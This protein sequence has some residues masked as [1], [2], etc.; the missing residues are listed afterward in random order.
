MKHPGLRLAATYP[1]RLLGHIALAV[2]I[3]LEGLFERLGDEVAFVLSESRKYHLRNLRNKRKA[4]KLK[5]T[6]TRDIERL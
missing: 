1:L 4:E 2:F 6:V 5:D 3:A